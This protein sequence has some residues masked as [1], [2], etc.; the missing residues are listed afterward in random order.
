MDVQSIIHDFSRASYGGRGKP[1]FTTQRKESDRARV[2][3]TER[4]AGTKKGSTVLCGVNAW[5]KSND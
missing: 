5:Y 4:H 3:I 1:F 2:A